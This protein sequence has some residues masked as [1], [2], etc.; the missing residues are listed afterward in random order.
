MM[1]AAGFIPGGGDRRDPLDLP[2]PPQGKGQRHGFRTASLIAS[3]PNADH[4]R[5]LIQKSFLGQILDARHNIIF[6]ICHSVGRDIKKIPEI[7][8]RRF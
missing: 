2:Q 7:L 8:L 6:L 1:G 3:E 4:Q 5:F